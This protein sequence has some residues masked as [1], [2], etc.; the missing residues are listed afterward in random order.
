MYVC[1]YVL[2][3]QKH[4]SISSILEVGQRCC[5]INQVVCIDQ[6]TSN[7]FFTATSHG[8]ILQRTYLHVSIY[9]IY[10]CT[11]AYTFLHTIRIQFVVRMWRVLTILIVCGGY[12]FGSVTYITL[13][14]L[15]QCQLLLLLLFEKC[16][17]TNSML[18]EQISENTVVFRL[19]LH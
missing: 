5:F 7:K 13:V 16:F 15:Q 9:T 14:Q 6:I 3:N 4:S 8:R 17:A 12:C 11:Y 1:M 10:I 19:T 2:Q 18:Y